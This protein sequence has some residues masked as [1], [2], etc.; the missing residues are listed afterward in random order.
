MLESFGVSP[1]AENVYLAMLRSP[2]TTPCQ[3]ATT[4]DM[5]TDEIGSAVHELRR[6]R[7]LRP[8]WR[9][10]DVVRPV[11]PAVALELLLS[12]QKAEL[13]R[14]QSRLAD[15]HAALRDLLADLADDAPRRSGVEELV[16]VD[17]VRERLEKLAYATRAEVRTFAPGGGQSA[18]ALTASRPLNQFLLGKGVRM[19][20]V[21]QDSARNHPA[22]GAHARWLTG[23]GA[24]VRTVPVLAVRMLVID[25]T[26]AVLPLDAEDS[27]AGA[28]V[29]HAPGAVTAMT[30]LFDH[31]WAT[32]REWAACP[33]RAGGCEDRLSRQDRAVLELLVQGNTDEQI[34]RRLGV[35][36]RT[37]G[38]ITAELMSRLR[39]RSRF[40]AGARAVANGWLPGG[41]DAPQ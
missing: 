18:D 23:L 34:G 27:A 19:S 38:R 35:S 15:G 4:L 8:S 13:Q 31:V 11:F 7:L 26:C 6:H 10:P 21:Y 41:P 17:A 5:T 12:R 32:A 20:T 24:Q 39:A 2:D 37:V 30:A 14:Q 28:F 1:I 22:T 29:I 33:D 36:T 40:Q 9:E 25:R 16:G 3:L